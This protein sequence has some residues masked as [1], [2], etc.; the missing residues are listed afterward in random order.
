MKKTQISEAEWPVMETLWKKGRATAGEIVQEVVLGRDVSMRTI[1]THIRRLIA[2]GAIGY[3]IDP[4]NSRL[5]HYRPLV[6]RDEAVRS[7]NRSFLGFVYNRDP[8]AL[9]DAFVEDNSLSDA[10]VEEIQRLLK[11][12]RRE[13]Q[14]R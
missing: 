14:E 11:R 3:S 10:E 2:K 8:V 1:K 9:L 13:S 5:Y 6:T 7:R 12:K 4:D